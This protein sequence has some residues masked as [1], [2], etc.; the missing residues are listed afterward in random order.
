MD[1]VIEFGKETEQEFILEHDLKEN[2][3]K[4]LSEFSIFCGFTPKII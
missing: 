1:E 4:I 3:L 2:D